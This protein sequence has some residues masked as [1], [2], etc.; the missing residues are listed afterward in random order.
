MTLHD[1]DAYSV[2]SDPASEGHVTAIKIL[3]NGIKTS[4]NRTTIFHK[5]A[6]I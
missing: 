4:E 2:G 6:Y 1:L 3:D 5:P